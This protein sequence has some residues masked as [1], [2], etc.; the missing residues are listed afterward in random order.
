MEVDPKKLKVAELKEELAKRGLDTSGLKGDLQQRLQAAL[1]EEEFGIDTSADVP[2]YDYDLE[3]KPTTESVLQKAE[4]NLSNNN[5]APPTNTVGSAPVTTPAAVSAETAPAEQPKEE[6]PVQAPATTTPATTTTTNEAMS[7]DAKRAARA[8]KFGIPLQTPSTTATVGDGNSTAEEDKLALRAARF[9][10]DKKTPEGGNGKA[11]VGAS[12]ESAEAIAKKKARAERFGIPFKEDVKTV[13]QQQQKGKK[14][15]NGKESAAPVVN[16]EEEAKRK[17][18]MMRFQMGISGSTNTVLQDLQ[19]KK[20]RRLER[21]GE[22]S[23]G[24]GAEA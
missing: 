3:S 23:A 7:E 5:S 20:K 11:A 6:P 19:E 22:P 1:D 12:K 13:K 17:A 9:Q 2:A 4:P 14:G 8:A 10:L 24:S 21:F 15:K 18:R 16:E